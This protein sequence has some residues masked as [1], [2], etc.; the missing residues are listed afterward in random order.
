MSTVTKMHCIWMMFF[1]TQMLGTCCLQAAVRTAWFDSGGCPRDLKT[2]A[3]Q[4]SPFV[5]FQLT[6]TSRWRSGLF[7]TSPKV[8]AQERDWSFSYL[9]VSAGLQC[10][11]S[12]WM[13]CEVSLSTPYKHNTVLQCAVVMGMQCW[14][15]VYWC[16]CTML[17]VAEWFFFP[18]SIHA[19]VSSKIR[20]WSFEK[21]FKWWLPYIGK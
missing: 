18:V 2:L 12:V 10:V 7:L 15:R 11:V 21:S 5:T 6:K 4:L 1:V 3:L 8:K 19:C 14:L 13:C 20:W 9:R 17:C 16:C